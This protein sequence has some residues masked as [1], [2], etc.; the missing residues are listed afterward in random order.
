MFKE[1]LEG[2]EQ[3]EEKFSSTDTVA[4]DRVLTVRV[5]PALY[6]LLESLTEEW[7]KAGVSDTVR[8]ILSMYFLPAIYEHSW[9]EMKPE[10]VSE[11]LKE[12]KEKGYSLNL[13]RFNR[14]VSE[15]LE[16]LEFLQE[17][18]ERGK[19]SLEYI[20]QVTDK[21]KTI[22]AA[23]EQTMQRAVEQGKNEM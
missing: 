17:A 5:E 10:R 23:T 2:I 4:K 16:Y 15:T 6:S 3:P 21:I 20:Q 13:T 22:I 18:Q 1:L 12:Q 8:T 7:S 14:F 9:K 19:A 11:N